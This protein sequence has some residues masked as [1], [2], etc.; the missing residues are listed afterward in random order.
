MADKTPIFHIEMA[1]RNAD[2]ACLYRQ[3]MTSRPSVGGAQEMAVTG[4]RE[5]VDANTM[6][7]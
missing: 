7:L 2:A 4:Q 6:A 1:I 3:H 5:N